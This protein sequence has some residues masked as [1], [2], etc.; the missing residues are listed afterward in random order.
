[1]LLG[2]PAVSWWFLAGTLVGLGFTTQATR[3]VHLPARRAIP[4]FFAGW[5]ANELAVHHVVWQAVATVAFIAAGALDAWPGWVGLAIGLVQWAMAWRLVRAAARTPGVVEAAVVEALGPEYRTELPDEPIGWD[6]PRVGPLVLPVLTAHRDVD[7]RRDIVFARA[8]AR[9]LAL[10]V[11]MPRRPATSRRPALVHVHGGA[12]TLGFRQRQGLPLLVEA[13]RRGFVG[14]Q[15]SY[16]LSP[17]ATFP[18]H[19]VDVKRAI[20]WVRDH[21][22]DLGVDPSYVAV[23]GGSAGGHLAALAAL[24]P[25][26]RDLQPG[27]EH[28]DTSVQAC[29]PIYGVYDPHGRYGWQQPD[30]IDFLARYVL[31]ADP[32]ADPDRWDT[33]SPAQQIR[34]DAPPF[35]VVHGE[36]D[37]LTSP[38]EARDFV[39]NLSATSGEGVGFALL[40]GAQHAFDVFPSIRTAHVVLAITRFLAVTRARASHSATSGTRPRG[41]P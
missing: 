38:Q 21:A 15:P 30:M 27:F 1:M 24:T 33:A 18:D 10:D 22:D 28:A 23:S 11:F 5:L 9:D 19:L 12:W 14:I 35:L 41:M 8:G 40:P 16:R 7:R 25:N 3:P 20:A 34:S 29:V 4:S 13:A 37:T 2:A 39:S 26:R 17:L 36:R 6:R 32:E 31:K